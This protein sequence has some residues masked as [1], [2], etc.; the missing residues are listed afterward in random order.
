MAPENSAARSSPSPPAARASARKKG[1]EGRMRWIRVIGEYISL[2]LILLDSILLGRSPVET[3]V[4]NPLGGQP[5]SI[6][7]RQSRRIERNPDRRRSAHGTR[8][9]PARGRSRNGWDRQ[10]EELRKRGPE[11]GMHE[12][13]LLPA[14]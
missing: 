13:L 3:Y 12:R 8:A 1:R 11:G 4:G 2:F 10:D 14:R 7:R 6:S 9:N 5:G